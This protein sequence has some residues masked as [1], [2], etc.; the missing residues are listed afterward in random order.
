MPQPSVDQEFLNNA[1][2]SSVKHV[3]LANL[4]H[5]LDLA[6]IP[7][8][9]ETNVADFTAELF[10]IL[11]Y[12]LGNRLV[13]TWVDF[14]L[15]ICGKSKH[16]TTKVCLI[17]YSQ[18]EYLLLVHKEKMLE[19]GESTNGQAQLVA[20]AVAVFNENNAQREVAGHPPLQEK[21]SHFVCLLTLF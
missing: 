18:N 9:G 11:K 19:H 17:D 16:A 15:L 5:Y 4:I 12:A 2:A 14:P 10:R 8:K 20:K 1:D 13:V 7:K 3:R 6:M 21:V